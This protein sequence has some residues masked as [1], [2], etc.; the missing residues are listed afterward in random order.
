MG[1]RIIVMGVSGS[2][3]STLAAQLGRAIACEVVDA[4]DFHDAASVVK[5]REGIALTDADRAPWL[6]RLNEMLRDRARA[7]Q[8][9]VLA[10]SALR[11]SYRQAIANDVTDVRWIFLDGEFEVIAARMR[12]RSA[13]TNH[14][15]PEALLRSQ[16]E[17]LERPRDAITVNVAMT[18]EAQLAAVMA[19]LKVLA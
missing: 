10:C 7:G 5:M 8:T 4:D 1:Y 6:A 17:T 18:S 19:A 12:E 3:K 14:Y 11:E 2:G 15:M 16:F 9:V 13:K